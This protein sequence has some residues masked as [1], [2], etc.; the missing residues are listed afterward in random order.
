MRTLALVIGNNNYYKNAKLDNAINDATA[1][2][3]VFE[4]LGF[5]VIS[6]QD[7]SADDFS[8][9]L[10]EF[11]N[12]IS[13]FDASIFYFAGHG[14][15]IDGEN[16][17]AA[18]DCQIDNNNKHHF[19]QTCI[20]LTEVLNI[21]K[22]NSNKIN[23]AI[24]DACRKTF[25]RGSAVAFSPIQAPKGTLLAFST[26]PNEG[27]SD[28][29]FEGHSIYT[30]AILKFIGREH[31]SVEE[32]FKKVRK[33]VYNI[34]EGKQT[35]WEHTSLIGDYY[36]NTG[37]LVYSVSIPYDENV[38]KDVNYDNNS[39]DFGILI[40][41]LKSY[42]WHI[43]NPAVES[44]LKI[45]V[46]D[47]DKNQQFI[48]GRNLLQS[49][50]SA[51]NSSIFM[52]SIATK[53]LKY[54]IDGENHVLNGILFEI[55]FNAQGEF[56]KDKTKKHYFSEIMALRKS[57]AFEKSFEFIR[58]L[59]I[60]TEYQLIYIPRKEDEIFD[61]D[62]VA[63]PQKLNNRHGKEDIFQVISKITWNSID[64]ISAISKHNVYGK[65]SEDLK[66]IIS[67]F[68]SVPEKQVQ[69]N[70]NIEL[71]RISIAI[72]MSEEDLLSPDLPF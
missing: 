37:Q 41:N 23:I 11:E 48:L 25:D 40:L 69:I 42:N 68:L 34:S 1:M 14:F 2:A 12:C 45:P 33:T 52:E 38:V 6:K 60:A 39:D 27:A 17:L 7:C 8:N 56:R 57:L 66:Q 47:L 24:V 16:Y 32:L 62:I 10:Y 15:E 35:S 63:T 44:L 31:L 70:C 19:G 54:S 64:L 59:L 61:I 28:I 13:Q 22:K 55:Y 5:Y 49:S 72:E 29:G 71:E 21:F 51:W 30:G 43:Q 9:L 50:G 4:R 20:R 46:N 67:N 36:F 3:E 65:D 58:H 18:I 53:I 26:S